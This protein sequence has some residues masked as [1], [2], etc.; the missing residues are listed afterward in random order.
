MLYLSSIILALIFQCSTIMNFDQQMKRHQRRKKTKKKNTV[1]LYWSCQYLVVGFGNWQM[2]YKPL[3]FGA[4]VLT[5][6][7]LYESFP[8]HPHLHPR[9]QTLRKTNRRF[10]VALLLRTYGCGKAQTCTLQRALCT[11]TSFAPYAL[12][13]G[14]RQWGGCSVAVNNADV[15]HMPVRNYYK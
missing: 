1:E 4:A 15:G 5:N 9:P 6:R 8:V 2:S 12:S 7:R 13:R 11:V 3:I 14:T 10:F